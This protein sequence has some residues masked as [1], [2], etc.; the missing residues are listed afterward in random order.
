MMKQR[1]L[2]PTQLDVLMRDLAPHRVSHRSQP[3]AGKLSY[4]EAWDVKAMLIRVFGFGG[5]SSEVTHTDILDIERYEKN[6]KPQVRVS[7]MVTVRL[8]IH[9]TGAVYTESAVSSQAG[10]TLGDVADFAVK[11]A[12]SDAFKRAAIFLGTGF[13]LSLY[14]DGSRSDVVRQVVAPGQQFPRP[15]PEQG[16]ADADVME[17]Q[18]TVDDALDGDRA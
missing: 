16:D 11:T 6:G 8:T 5:F 12:A 2:T 10:S 4:V 15:E 17:G 7:A 9:Q 14:R 1:K 13:G 18:T 3:G